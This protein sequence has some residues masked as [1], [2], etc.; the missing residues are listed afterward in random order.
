MESNGQPSKVHLSPDTKDAL[1][2]VARDKY[3]IEIRGEIPI[4]VNGK[5]F[6]F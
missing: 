3:K 2:K 6:I 5:Q 4:K 1:E